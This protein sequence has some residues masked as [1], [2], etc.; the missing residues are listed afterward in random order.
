MLN[1]SDEL[2]T[3]WDWF[4]DILGQTAGAFSCGALG[5]GYYRFIQIPDP[6]DT[7]TLNRVLSLELEEV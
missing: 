1:T 4:N 7:D 3:F 5:D 2:P 6:E